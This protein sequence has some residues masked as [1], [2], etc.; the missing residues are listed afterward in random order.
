MLSP[1]GKQR[2]CEKDSGPM[3]ESRSDWQASRPKIARVRRGGTAG[4]RKP[5]DTR[6]SATRPLEGKRIVLTRAVEQARGLMARLENHGRDCAVCFQ[7][8]VFPNRADTADL[9]RAIRSLGAY[10]W[11]LFTSA[12]AVRFFA[13]P[14]PQ[15]W[16]GA[17]LT[18]Q[19][20]AAPRSARQP[21]APWPRKDF[22]SITWRRNLLARRWRASFPRRLRE[23]RFYCRAASARGPICR[24]R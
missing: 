14:L 24:M 15:A 4:A 23:R 13:A 9:D 2:M 3:P 7:P 1:D 17:R 16:C 21:P 22:P 6:M 11:I 18:R 20:S 8:S 12:N 10:D 19:A 5:R